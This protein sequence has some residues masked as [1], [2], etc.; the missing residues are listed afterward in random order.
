LSKRSLNIEIN[1]EERNINNV[2]ILIYLVD[3][4]LRNNLLIELN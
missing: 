1:R 2:L 3:L 4:I